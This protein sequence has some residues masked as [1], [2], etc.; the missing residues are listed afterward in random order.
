LAP[1]VSALLVSALTFQA[2][3]GVTMSNSG[4]APPSA[5]ALGIS[6]TN[7]GGA[8]NGSMDYSDNGGALGQSFTLG[9]ANVELNALSLNANAGFGASAYTAGTMWNVQI[10]RYDNDAS[11]PFGERTNVPLVPLSGQY[12]SNT[13]TKHTFTAIAAIGTNPAGGDWITFTFTGADILVLEGGHTY[14]FQV[15]NTGGEG[16][17]AGFNIANSDAYAGGE[18]FHAYGSS[19]FSD[20]Y[21]N[22]QSATDR[23]FVLNLS[24]IPD[25]DSDGMIDA[26]EITYFG[27]LSQTGSA[28]GDTDGLTDLQEHTK[29]T[30][31]ILTDTDGDTLSDG[32]ED[33]GS[34]NL[35]DSAP[36]NPLAA[37]SDNDKV[38]DYDEVHG[39]LNTSFSL[40][41]TNPNAAD[42]DGDGA[43]DHKELVYHSNPNDFGNLPTPSLFYLI[44]NTVQNG[45]FETKNGGTPITTKISQWDVVGDDIDNWTEWGPLVAGPSTVAGDSGAEPGGSD[46]PNL[47]AGYFQSGNAAFN[48]TANIA[49]EGSIYA[50]TWKQLNRGGDTISVQLV[51]KDASNNI[52]AIPQSLTITNT[53]GGL[54]EL[55]YQI[56]VGSPAI[57]HEIGIGVSSQ[58]YWIDAD[59]FA[60]NIA[61]IGDDDGD[62]LSNIWETANGLNPNSAVGANGA[63]GDPDGDSFT[64]LDEQ[65]ASS[66]PQLAASTP[67]DT[68]ADGLGDNWELANF[69]SLSG[70]SGAPGLDPDGDYDTNLVEFTNSTSPTNKF[71][72]YTSIADTVPD[73]WKTH[74]GIALSVTGLDDSDSDL[75]TN[76]DE[77]IGATNPTNAD[78][79]GDGLND[80]NEVNVSLTDPLDTDSDNDGLTDGAEVNT[81]L[82]NPLDTDSDDDG[83]QDGIEVTAGS[84]PAL[85][86]ST[87]VT[88]TGAI[89]LID[90][91]NRNG[92]FE[93][94]GGIASTAK[95]LH[96]DTDPNGNVDN[97][98]LWDAAASG[99]ATAS[100][101]SATEASGEASQGTRIAFLQP[102]NAAYNRAGRVIAAGDV[103]TYTW[104]WVVAGRGNA[105]AQLGY[106]DS[107][108]NG[109]AGGALAIIG[110]ETANPNATAR[111]LGLGS[112]WTVQ[113]G[114]PAIGKEI[115]M[116]I[117]SN[118]NYP[119]IDN[120][121]LSVMA[122]SSGSD[123]DSD[124][125]ADAWETTYFG[126][127]GQTA[128]GDFENDGT[129]N[130]TEFRLGLIPNNGSSS[131]VAA[132]GNVG[133]IQ[134]PSVTGVT[135]RIERST[136][137][138]PSSWTVLETNLPGSADTTSYT[139]PSPPV[140][141]AFYKIGLNP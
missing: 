137:L 87:P 131:F 112:T 104:D 53:A 92:S 123:S 108:A 21:V 83:Y 48:L 78:S 15:T 57:G 47:R 133:L 55:I 37:D 135:F 126:G 50:C 54:G 61:A 114:D 86:A 105:T 88:I 85:A 136:S 29:G 35:F 25:S 107:A 90:T 129:D 63:L 38:S 59:E 89:V 125:M 95:A 62:G 8:L 76:E 11:G 28:D 52:V 17:W 102:G 110:T 130:L 66:N 64:N 1:T 121:V 100:G 5:G 31:P 58:G 10:T 26:W 124:G 2:Q 12:T 82:T 127:L 98:T 101:D 119:V 49:A 81:H 68:D 60:L 42:T 72:F 22:G 13:F 99:P 138:A 117:M 140:G 118:G 65:A 7:I 75:I 14:A 94:L 73:A 103:F 128:T 46:G 20:N 84:N 113:A 24:A 41:A 6:Q 56:P 106:W 109:G 23:A 67:L 93:L 120:F 139:D 69:G 34:G 4:A 32:A 18:R 141:K 96:W 134:W 44:S 116:L 79:D 33:S 132:R 30:N 70:P 77:F 111:H 39:T 91:L 97:W 16:Q 40:E 3:A 45:S 51:Y 80:G 115:V 19:L 71:S 43:N 9:A 36:T 122:A 74:F 27:N